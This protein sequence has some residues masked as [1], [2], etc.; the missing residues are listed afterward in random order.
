M[1]ALQPREYIL[2]S[3][4]KPNAKIAQG[5]DTTVVTRKSGGVVAGSFVAED[6]GQLSLK[7]SDGKVVVVPKSDIASRATGPSPMPE[8]F[9][10]ILTKAEIRDL[11]EFVSSLKTKPAPKDHSKPR[12]LR[13]AP[14]D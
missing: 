14:V 5:F 1:R 10:A 7:N 8:I 11:V 4:V 6:D 2:E 9:G 3:I 12:A 13:P